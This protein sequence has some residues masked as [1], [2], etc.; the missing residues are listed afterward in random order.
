MKY[1]KGLFSNGNR[2]QVLLI[3]VLTTIVSL[4][5]GLTIVSRTITNLKISK[6][7]EESQRAFQ[8]AEGGIEQ[9][10]SSAQTG[11]PSLLTQNFSNSSS[12][13][14]KTTVISAEGGNNILLNNGESVDQDSGMDVWLS[15]YP[16]YSSPTTGDVTIF[17]SNQDIQLSGSPEK[18]GKTDGSSVHSALEVVLLSGSV[19]SPTFT[20]KV[21]DP[22]ARI[23]SSD[24]YDN[25]TKQ[26]VG[27]ITFN[28]QATISVTNGLIMKVIPIYNSTKIAVGS[29]VAL[30]SQGSLIESTGTSGDTVRKVVYYSSYPQIPLEIFPYSV[31]SQ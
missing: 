22:C 18:C 14:T 21:F 17:W 3:V 29:S 5:V 30:P 27:G 1:C 25:V 4:T 16:D 9:A 23:P 24:I 2:G 7:N 31:I 6:Q 8:A 10:L 15:T 26:T 20:K 19:T 12:S 28:Y 11:N 13:D